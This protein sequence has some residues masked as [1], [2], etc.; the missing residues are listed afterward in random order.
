MATK[1][2]DIAETN[3]VAFTMNGKV[4]GYVTVEVTPRGVEFVG[5]GVDVRNYD[6]ENQKF[7]GFACGMAIK[8]DDVADTL[9]TNFLIHM[10]TK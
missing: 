8:A 3:A 4:V 1:A 9:L 7:N 2:I 10:A 5:R 6:Y